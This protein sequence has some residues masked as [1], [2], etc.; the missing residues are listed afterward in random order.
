MAKT[1]VP[2]ARVAV[3]ANPDA[4]TAPMHIKNIQAAAQKLVTNV[5][6]LYARTPEEIDAMRRPVVRVRDAFEEDKA[7]DRPADDTKLRAV[8]PAMRREPVRGN[9]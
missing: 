6:V 8:E 5:L 2:Q 1:V 4:P 7:D 9:Q 3:L